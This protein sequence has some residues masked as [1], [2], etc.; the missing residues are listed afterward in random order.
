M[1][2]DK[3]KLTRLRHLVIGHLVQTRSSLALAA[4]CLL[5]ALLMELL[6]PWPLK[7]IFDH[8]LM[9]KPLAHSWSY[10]GGLFQWRPL[11]A[12]AILAASVF[13]MA[14]VSGACSYAQVYLV[15]KS[16]YQLAAKLKV[17][18]CSPLQRLSLAFHTH[19]PS[20]EFV[21]KMAS[22]TTAIRDLFT[23]WGVRALYQSSVISGM[24]VVMIVVNWRLALVVLGS[25]PVLFIALARL[26]QKLRASISRQ[27][28]QEG[29]IASRMNEVLGAIAMVQA[30]GRREFDQDRFE[31]VAARNRAE[32][33]NSARTTAAVTR[34]IEVIRELS[35]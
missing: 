21:V 29:R 24:L 9:G 8:V 31:V 7:L 27:R 34:V 35:W 26:N 17:K 15:T 3:V 5:G 12:V 32:A 30:I 19:V 23:D 28:K 33:I 18:L 22:D 13:V 6:A 25:I 10:L 4:L 16:S 1:S 14:L 20:G 2:M 11:T